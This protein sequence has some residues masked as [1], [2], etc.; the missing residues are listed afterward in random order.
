[1]VT[2]VSRATVSFVAPV[3]AALIL[4]YAVGVLLARWYIPVSILAIC[5]GARVFLLPN[6]FLDRHLFRANGTPR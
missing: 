1:M 6:P 2:G 4:A 5:G 3:H